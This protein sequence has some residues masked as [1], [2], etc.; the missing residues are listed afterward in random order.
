MAIAANTQHEQE[1]NNGNTLCAD[2]GRLNLQKLMR[3][4][5]D[6]SQEEEEEEEEDDG[7]E[8]EPNVAVDE[9]SNR[10]NELPDGAPIGCGEKMETNA[11]TCLDERNQIEDCKVDG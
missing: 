4:K 7:Q 8:W 5:R 3:P 2:L 11:S 6:E 10:K 9:D 1:R